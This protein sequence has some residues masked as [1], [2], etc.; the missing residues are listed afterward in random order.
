MTDTFQVLDFFSQKTRSNPQAVYEQMRNTEPV[1]HTIGPISGSTFW[2]LTRY[3]DC[4][5]MLKM[6]QVGKEVRKHM[7][8]ELLARFPEPTGPFA[9]IGRHLLD[10]DP[11][12]HTRLRSMVH[13]AFTPGIVENLR[14]RIQQIADD[15][16]DKMQ[17]KAEVDLIA[18]FGFPLPIIVIAELIGIPSEDRDRF[19]YWTKQILFGNNEQEVTA[20][21]FEF[22]MYMHN[23]IDLRRE[24][25]QNDLL[26]GLVV[27]KED[28]QEM[29]RQEL[30]SMLF[31]L[32]VAGH[33][34][35]VNLIGNG[36]LLLLEHPDQMQKLQHDPSLIRSA[37][38]EMLRYNGPVETTTFR[39]AF[40]DVQIGGKTIP[41]GDIIL[42]SLLGA[43]RDPAVFDRPNE[44]DITRDSNKH[45][46]FGNGIHYCVGAPLARMEGAIAINTLLRRLPTLHLQPGAE[47]SLEWSDSIL[48]HGLKALPVA[49]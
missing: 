34:T 16:I 3:D 27:A 24:N 4:V 37:V 43:N 10:I 35:T 19:R 25:P 8:P 1:Y 17:N 28:G 32:L 18:D 49:F 14:P 9:A 6:P 31:L 22:V 30:I 15:L 26:S 39:Y 47:D 46:A 40:E 5:N 42:A 44:F 29:D 33:E 38:E 23:M 13:K 48:I 36:T 20:A 2:V 41:Q 45:I 21:A 11:P 7:P 12:D